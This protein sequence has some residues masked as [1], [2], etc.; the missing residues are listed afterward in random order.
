M[1]LLW[2]MLYNGRSPF[3]GEY[4]IFCDFT[5]K[6]R[7]ENFAKIIVQSHTN[8]NL[9]SDNKSFSLCFNESVNDLWFTAY[10]IKAS[11]PQVN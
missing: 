8:T 3:N 7:K 11:C 5:L 4:A 1:M 10:C 9:T 2:P 6:K